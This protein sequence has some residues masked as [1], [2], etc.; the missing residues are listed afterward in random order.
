MRNPPT[1]LIYG[2]SSREKSLF[3]K[4]TV[5]TKFTAVLLTTA[6]ARKQP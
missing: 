2:G 5:S 6:T 1:G 4:G 3:E